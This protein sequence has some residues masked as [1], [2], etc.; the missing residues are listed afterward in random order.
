MKKIL[1]FVTAFLLSTQSYI[2]VQAMAIDAHLVAKLEE[3]VKLCQKES[4]QSIDII[5]AAT[6]FL[7]SFGGNAILEKLGI[8]TSFPLMMSLA[9]TAGSA[10]SA[11][12]LSNLKDEVKQFSGELDQRKSVNESDVNLFLEKLKRYQEEVRRFRRFLLQA[13]AY[14]LSHMILKK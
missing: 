5:A 6:P 3:Q 11:F 2:P 7:M 8:E 13:S 4:E 10:M 12:N 1:L 9:A 14:A